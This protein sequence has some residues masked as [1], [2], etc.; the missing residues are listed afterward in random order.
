LLD[1]DKNI[2]CQKKKSHLGVKK[3]PIQCIIL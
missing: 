3:S 2:I 1:S